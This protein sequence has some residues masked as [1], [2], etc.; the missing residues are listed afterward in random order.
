MLLLSAIS[1]LAGCGDTTSSGSGIQ[2]CFSFCSSPTYPSTPLPPPRS[3]RPTA[4]AGG[5]SFKAISIGDS[6]VCA[7]TTA[8]DAYCW[9]AIGYGTPQATVADKPA[10]VPGGIKFDTISV[11]M[12]TACG[13]TTDQRT[14]CWG[15]N[16]VGQLGNGSYGEGAW[17]PTPVLPP[18]LPPGIA[19]K[20]IA[21]GGNAD[22]G[23]NDLPSAFACGLAVTGVVFCWGSNNFGQIGI[24][25]GKPNTV[26][27]GPAPVAGDHVF[28]ALAGNLFATACGIDSHGAAL[29]WGSNARN[30]FGMDSAQSGAFPPTRVAKDLRFVALSS[31]GATCGITTTG[32]TYCWGSAGVAIGSSL[33][34][35]LITSI[36]FVSIAAGL[37]HACGLTSTGMAYCWGSNS[38]GELGDGTTNASTT[39]VLVATDLRFVRIEAGNEVTCALTASGAAYCWGWDDYYLLGRGP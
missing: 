19:Y 25:A 22:Y 26:Y 7:V 9:G 36:P 16:A 38:I 29:C 14:M 11:G 24:G 35:R 13:I 21:V 39:P 8:G 1:V 2:L 31:G 27:V 23:A 18:G 20:S 5:L 12:Y 15:A 30:E 37:T 34:P 10:L 4:V 33:T 32:D 28:T 17:M 6:D 3:L